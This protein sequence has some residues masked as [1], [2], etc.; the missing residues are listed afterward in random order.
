MKEFSGYAFHLLRFRG[1]W[2]KPFTAQD[3]AGVRNAEREL[4]IR[5]HPNE[6]SSAYGP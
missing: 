4:L 3:K 2:R 5:F 1:H 6:F